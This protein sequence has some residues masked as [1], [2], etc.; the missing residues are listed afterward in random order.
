MSEVFE[1]PAFAVSGEHANV[2]V[3]GRYTKFARTVSQTKWIVD[4]KRLYEHSIEEEM[5]GPL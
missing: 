4:G 3:V 5:A 2:M 1:S